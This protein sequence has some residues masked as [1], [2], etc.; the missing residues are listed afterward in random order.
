MGNKVSWENAEK[1]GTAELDGKIIMDKP[2]KYGYRVVIND[3]RVKPL[4]E[5]FKRYKNTTILS[6]KERLEFETYIIGM[7]KKKP[8]DEH[9]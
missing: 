9:T 8:K 3:P 1:C 7:V 2:N 6:D 4:Y 5:R